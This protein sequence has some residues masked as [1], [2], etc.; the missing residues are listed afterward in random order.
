MNR[1]SAFRSGTRLKFVAA[2]LAAGAAGLAMAGVAYAVHERP[3]SASPHS[4]PLVLAYAQCTAPNTNHA[5]P[6]AF[7][8]CDPP[9]PRSA[10]L[11]TGTTG[12]GAGR[13]KFT[14]F[15]TNAQAPPCPAPGD[16]EDIQVQFNASDVRCRVAM[17]AGFCA[18]DGDHLRQLILTTFIRTTDHANGDPAANCPNPAGAAPCVTATVTDFQLALVGGCVANG[19]AGIGSAC[20]ANTTFDA[21]LPGW[22]AEQQRAETEIGVNLVTDLGADGSFGPN[23]PPVCG[24]GDERPFMAPGVLAP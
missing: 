22:V 10:L 19:G 24:T 17:P 8:S 18:A 23:C 20:G 11:A 13:I 3:G 21:L 6:F 5:P 2:L 4:V 14:V 1:R 9:V 16:Q 15:C 7:Q 12:A